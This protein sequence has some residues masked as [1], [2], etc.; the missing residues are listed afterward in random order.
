M[1]AASFSE[2]TASAFL[3]SK[4]TDYTFSKYT[5]SEYSDERNLWN[6]SYQTVI[7]NQNY[8]LVSLLAKYKNTYS[9]FDEVTSI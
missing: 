3:V 4:I 7:G 6:T 8:P 1:I 5:S 2:T 9:I